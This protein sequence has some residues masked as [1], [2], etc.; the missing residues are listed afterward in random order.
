MPNASGFSDYYKTLSN[1]DILE[2]LD[3]PANY[4]PQ[5]VEAAQQELNSRQ[6]TEEE[7]LEAGAPLL[8][9]RLTRIKQQEKIKA[10]E[11]KVKSAGN[12]FADTMNPVVTETPTSTKLLRIITVVNAL[13]FLYG[14]VK[15]YRFIPGIIS[16]MLHFYPFAA[17]LL[18]LMVLEPIALYLLWKRKS[19]G[20]SLFTIYLTFAAISSILMFIDALRRH[21]YFAGGFSYLFNLRSSPLPYFIQ[22]VFSAGTLYVLC[23]PIIRE[24]YSIGRRK[25]ISTIVITGLLSVVYVYF[26][27]SG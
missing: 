12:L 14:L 19:I 11:E 8:V 4:E 26:I 6:L 27:V 17:L 20:W 18:L 23:K 21:F 15:E 7:I 13:Y 9:K 5:A 2:I 25:M 16:D 24:V 22:L 10:I 3:A 1:T